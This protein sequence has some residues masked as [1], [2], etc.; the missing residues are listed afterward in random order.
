MTT[1]AYVRGTADQFDVTGR[2][3]HLFDPEGGPTIRTFGF[4]GGLL[5][6]MKQTGQ[7]LCRESQTR[8]LVPAFKCSTIYTFPTKDRPKKNVK[9]K[10][11][12]CPQSLNFA[13][14]HPI[15]ENRV[16]KKDILPW[17]VVFLIRNTIAVYRKKLTPAQLRLLEDLCHQIIRTDP[18]AEYSFS[19]W[20]DSLELV[21]EN[22]NPFSEETKRCPGG[23]PVQ[24][25]AHP[26]EEISAA[27]EFSVHDFYTRYGQLAEALGCE[28]RLGFK[29]LRNN[30]ELGLLEFKLQLL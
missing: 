7:M 1:E 11:P 13:A 30:N 21:K 17:F 25:L 14:G 27:F 23:K 22:G 26:I 12:R 5:W 8:S 9:G 15:H 24:L 20:T 29:E 18:I 3:T 16:Q 19:S 2:P 10:Y 6:F 4:R 28:L